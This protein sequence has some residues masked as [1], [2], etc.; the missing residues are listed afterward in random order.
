VSCI[1][2]PTQQCSH[3]FGY[4]IT[5]STNSNGETMHC[6][7]PRYMKA[8]CANPNCVNYGMLFNIAVVHGPEAVTNPPERIKD[9]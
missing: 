9:V 5:H 4:M 3:C 7:D 2:I 1:G 6:Q 8:S